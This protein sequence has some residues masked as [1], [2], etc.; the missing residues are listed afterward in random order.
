M[1][2]HLTGQILVLFFSPSLE[3]S[4]SLVSMLQCLVFLICCFNFFSNFCFYFFFCDFCNS[5]VILLPFGKFLLSRGSCYVQSIHLSHTT[6]QPQWIT[7][8]DRPVR[9]LSFPPL[10]F[11]RFWEKSGICWF[12]SLLSPVCRWPI[13]R[14]GNEPCPVTGSCRRQGMILNKLILCPSLWF[15]L[16]HSLLN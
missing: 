16:S 14:E 10:N 9:F 3:F 6:L 2:K 4:R 13:V 1:L 7:S 5:V 15:V 11:K 8:Q 12:Y